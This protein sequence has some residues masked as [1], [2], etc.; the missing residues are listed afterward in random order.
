MLKNCIGTW[1]K[2]LAASLQRLL[3]AFCG[4]CAA[5]SKST[6]KLSTA[7]EVS[8]RSPVRKVDEALALWASLPPSEQQRL[9][10]LI[11]DLKQKEQPNEQP[12]ATPCDCDMCNP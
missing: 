9:H 11:E 2:R 10:R 5:R 6:T 1:S 4:R 12:Y 7:T 3:T 8:M